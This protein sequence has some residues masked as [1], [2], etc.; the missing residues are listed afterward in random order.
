MKQK[1]LNS[2]KLERRGNEKFVYLREK[3]ILEWFCLG[4][5]LVFAYITFL[6]T[7]LTDTYENSI[8]FLKTIYNGDF[9]QFYSYTVENSRTLWAANYDFM[10]YFVYGIWNLPVLLFSSMIGIDYLYWAPGLFWCKTLGILLCIGTAW[11]IYKIL[12]YVK[13][14]KQMAL[15][16]SFL[17]L[18][19]SAL[20][21]IVFIIA[22][23]DSFALFLLVC[24]FYYYIK[25]QQGRFLLCF[26]IAM[27]CKMFAIFLFIPLI[28]LKEKRICFV[29]GNIALVFSA[30]LISKLIFWGDPAYH[31]AL[32]S[33]SRDAMIQIIDS[34]IFWGQNVVLFIFCY[35]GI[36]VFC[37]LYEGYQQDR[38]K[39]QIPIFCA[40]A[41]WVCF[42]CFVN[43]NS[44]W[45]IYL[46]PFLIIGIVSRGRFLKAC[47]LLEM[48]FSVGYLGVVVCYCSPLNDKHLIRRL[49]LNKICTIPD[50][51]ITRYGSLNY[52]V[53]DLGL[54]LLAPVFSTF[55]VG[56]LII[57]L[58]L[59]CPFLFENVSCFVMP[60]SL[61]LFAR[62]GLMALITAIIMYAYM[63]VAPPAVYS[64][65]DAPRAVCDTD[66]IVSE[67]WIG[68]EV[69]LKE[70]RRMEELQLFFENP[71][72]IR[73]NFSSVIV[74]IVSLENARPIFSKRI[75]CSMIPSGERKDIKL[76]D[77]EMEA[78]KRYLIKITGVRGSLDDR[79]KNRRIFPYVTETLMDSEYPAYINGERQNYNLYFRLR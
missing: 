54:D 79:W 53:N 64:T 29:L 56:A 21:L 7:D 77:L 3:L 43:F 55:M 32:G 40:A 19:S 45:G 73:N 62:L 71:D 12:S 25:G 60:E 48:V 18:S 16:G 1:L 39:Y 50:Y 27:P 72:Y 59:V 44:Y 9:T 10:I 22:Q 20:F 14:S 70:S 24:G 57:L 11:V 13:V 42:V 34:Q 23:A 17:F 6:Y 58:V 38:E 35:M 76:N 65:L 26:T 15:F 46:I 51:N 5:I 28:L 61:V 68:Q 49:F 78:G 52:M 31:F 33:Q 66:L 69:Q 41:V 2:W 4:A 63:K 37:Y 75:G 47:C 30:S 74:E 36:C 67:N 8:L